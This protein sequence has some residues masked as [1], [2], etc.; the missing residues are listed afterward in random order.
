MRFEFGQPRVV[1][2][3]TPGNFVDMTWAETFSRQATDE[4][5]R[6]WTERLER[7]KAQGQPQLLAEAKTLE[8]ER[9]LSQEYIA[10]NRTDEEF[11]SDVFQSYLLREPTSKEMETWLKVLNGISV[12]SPDNHSLFLEQFEN[13][14]EF[15]DLIYS[16][17]DEHPPQLCDLGEEEQCNYEG[18]IW[19]SSECLC[20]RYPQDDPR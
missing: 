12:S 16:L 14:Q 3:Y 6:H 2:R 15:A 20:I 7:A 4:E 10:R 11:I 13:I 5:W 19:D 8:R 18:G 17:V 1:V 9:F